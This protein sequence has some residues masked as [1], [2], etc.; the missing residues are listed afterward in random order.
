MA[1]LA[2]CL[3]PC[4]AASQSTGSAGGH[5]TIDRF[6]PD[7]SSPDSMKTESVPF[8]P[9]FSVA[10]KEKNTSGDSTWIILTEKEPPVA[11]WLAAADRNEARRT[12]C[13]KEKTPFVALKLDPEM[14]PDLYF[15]CPGNGRVNTEMISTINGLDSVVVKFETKEGAK[16]K[17]TL[18]GGE[19]N[20]PKD[21]KDQYCVQKSDYTFDAPLLSKVG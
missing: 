11:E 4:L 12:W 1:L 15:L 21:E 17:G 5:G 14:K 2:P 8:S 7:A 18:S 20:C 16:L 6:S 13:E 9:R 10:L 3:L 19:G